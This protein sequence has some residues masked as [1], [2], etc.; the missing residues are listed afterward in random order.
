MN[1]IQFDDV[2]DSLGWSARLRWQV[3]PGNE[4][5]FVY[6]RSWIRRSD[7]ARRFDPA[8]ERGVIKIT[9]SF[10]P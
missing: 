4:V 7:R 8:G 10:R 9:L 6:N 5:Y 1:Y 2:S 3:S